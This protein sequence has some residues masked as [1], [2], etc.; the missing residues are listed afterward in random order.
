MPFACK[1]DIG[2]TPAGDQVRTPYMRSPCYQGE[3][4][5]CQV[6]VRKLGSR[7]GSRPAHR[8][9]SSVFFGGGLC[10]GVRRP[11][12]TA[13]IHPTGVAEYRHDIHTDMPCGKYYTTDI[14]TLH[15]R[16]FEFQHAVDPLPRGHGSSSECTVRTRSGFPHPFRFLYSML[17]ISLDFVH[18]AI[19]AFVSA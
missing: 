17:S 1:I 18:I 3:I 16:P 15:Y 12:S 5:P 19:A 13:P 9:C 8:R 11:D 14:L 4:H 7:T 10:P 6:A 2:P